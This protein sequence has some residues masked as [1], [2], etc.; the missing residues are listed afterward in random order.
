[1]RDHGS[2]SA[3]SALHL[4]AASIKGTKL[5]WKSWALSKVMFFLWL[6]FLGWLWTAARRFRHGLQV[7]ATCKF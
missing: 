4:G 6:A 3:Y 5:I 7:D 1:M 2:S